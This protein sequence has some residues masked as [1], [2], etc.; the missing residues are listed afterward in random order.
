[1]AILG[2]KAADFLVEIGTEELPPTALR[3]LMNAFVTNLSKGFEENRLSCESLTPFASPRRLAVIADNLAMTQEDREIEMRG[4]PVKVAFDEDGNPAAAAQAFA[5]KCGVTVTRLGREET[6]KGEYLVHKTVERG[7]AAAELIP[8]I[9]E[10]ALA[11]LPIPRRMRWGDSD[12]EFVRPVH[13]VILMH[14]KKVVDGTVLGIKSGAWSRGHRFMAPGEIKISEPKS[15]PGQLEKEGFVIADFEQRKH[16]ITAGV[17]QL[18]VEV[19]GQIV[20]DD[21]LF[22]EVTALTEWPVALVGSFDKTFLALPKEVITAT[23]TNHQRY[24]PI[25]GSKGSLLSDFVTVTNIESRDP[26]IVRTGNERVIQPR[27][28]DAAFFWESD[29]KTTLWARRLALKKTVYQKGLGTLAD[30]SKRI[31]NLSKLIANAIGADSKYA[32]RA[33]LLAKCDL[34]TGMVGEFPELQGVMGRHY[35]LADGEKPEV[36][37]AIGEQYLPRFAG[38]NLPASP[39]GQALAIADRVDTLAGVFALGN[40]P[41]GNRD[42][43]GLR[44][45]ALGI[46]RI[47]VERELDLDI[48]AILEAA[49]KA[50]PPKKKPA[51]LADDLYDFIT[52]RMRSWYIERRGVSPEMFEAVRVRKPASLVDFNQRIVAVS[53]FV[54][55]ESAESLASANKRIANILRKAEFDMVEAT[56]TRLLQEE[57]EQ[58]LHQALQAATADIAPLMRKRAYAEALTRLAD[59]RESIDA[60]FDDV[61]V[62]VDDEALRNNRLALLTELRALFLAIADISRLSISA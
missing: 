29:Q 14:G 55:L 9:V 25:A 2:R 7:R 21:A 18:A 16:K 4:P 13:W 48:N 51:T 34:Q 44:R 11:E 31:A 58:S 62:M 6:D 19:G 23:L 50:Q 37:T 53:A 46:F 57:A 60:F 32:E 41:S 59:L 61:M 30:K 27:L 1:M 49:A 20:A 28:A 45:A 10:R 40:T 39:A 24:F 35:A 56:Q 15:Y 8:G 26:D 33:G 3:N 12:A 42:P 17:T 54:R 36:A 52:E 38:D 47:I 22:D 5:E 43:F